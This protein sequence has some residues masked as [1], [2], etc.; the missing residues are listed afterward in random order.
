L[1]HTLIERDRVEA[2]ILAGTELALVFD[3][4]NTDFPNVNGAQLHLHAI[5][6]RALVRQAM[7]PP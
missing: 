5:V 7:D 6:R 2:V 1:A 4:K 3:E